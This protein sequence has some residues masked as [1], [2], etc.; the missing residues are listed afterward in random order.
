MGSLLTSFVDSSIQL[1][2]EFRHIVFE[3]GML[4]YTPKL[5]VIM[6]MTW[7]E[8]IANR[9]LEKRCIL[10]NDCQATPKV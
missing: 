7:I 4:K 9:A 2:G 6:Y 1:S 5:C 10:R 8:V 3:P